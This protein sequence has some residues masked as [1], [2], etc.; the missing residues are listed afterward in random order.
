[1]RSQWVGLISNPSYSGSPRVCKT[2]TR[3]ANHFTFL[4]DATLCFNLLL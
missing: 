1:M 3:N 4:A 2:C